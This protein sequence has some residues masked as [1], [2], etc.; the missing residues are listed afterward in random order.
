MKREDKDLY[1]A[2]D[3]YGHPTTKGVK[4]AVDETIDLKRMEIV[5]PIGHEAGYN[6]F[7]SVILADSE[8]VICKVL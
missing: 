3:D 2:F 8:G 4:R 5:K 1:I 7:N 6:I